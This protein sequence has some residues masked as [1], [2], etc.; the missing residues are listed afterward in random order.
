MVCLDVIFDTAQ[1]KIQESMQLG[2]W[3]TLQSSLCRKGM[4]HALMRTGTQTRRM[5]EA[6]RDLWVH[7][8]QSCPSRDTQNRGPRTTSRQLL[9]ISKEETPQLL[10]NMCRA[11][12]LTAQKYSLVF[13]RSLL[14][15]SSCP[16]PLVLA[17]MLQSPNH[18]CGPSL[19]SLQ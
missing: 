13:R 7:L 17:E 10:G 15:S 8:A 5:A 1:Q 12:L 18:F 6:G 19:N 4:R 2:T 16:L 14:Y 11:Q 3:K 9:E